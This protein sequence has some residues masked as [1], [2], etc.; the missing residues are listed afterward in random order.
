MKGQAIH[1]D[2][3][4]DKGLVIEIKKIERESLGL[5]FEYHWHDQLQFFYF[6]NGNAIV[7]CDLS[8]LEVG[9]HDL[10]IINGKELHYIES[11]SENLTFYIIKIDLSFIYSNKIDGIQAQFLTPLSQNLILF[12]NVVRNDKEVLRCI[13]RMIEEYYTKKIGFE[14]AIKAQIYDLIVLL[15]RGHTKKIYD[16]EGFQS[17]RE[18]LLHFRKV[19]DFMD[20]NFTEKIDLNRLSN[21]AGISVGHFCRLFKQITGVSAID[22]VNKL[23]INKAVELIKNSDLNMTEIAMNCGFSDSNYFS[24]IFK[25]HERISPTHMRNESL[26]L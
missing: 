13:I 9:P 5:I 12:E 18:T 3:M 11:I 26:S 16:E 24:R 23:R 7:R 4:V 25:K 6:T 10:I 21:I 2:D 1:Y 15:L 20:H 22:Y 17:R 19:I 8:K 14:L